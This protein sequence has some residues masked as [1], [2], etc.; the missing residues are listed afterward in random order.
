MRDCLRLLLAALG[1]ITCIA[2][3]S[4]ML[5]DLQSYELDK[6]LFLIKHP[7]LGVLL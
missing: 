2:T 3:D 6:P 4:P 7:D 5:L 1:F